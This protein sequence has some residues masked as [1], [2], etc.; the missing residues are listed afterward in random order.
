[1]K[2][3]PVDVAT[4]L[5]ESGNVEAGKMIRD[6]LKLAK[7]YQKLCT[8][9]RIGSHQAPGNA[10]KSIEEHGWMIE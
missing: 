8:V 2:K 10:L 6:L 9:Y 3:K 1:M 7:A 4:E 5:E